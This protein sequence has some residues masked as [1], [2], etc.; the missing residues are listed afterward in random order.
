M[1][2]KGKGG[3]EGLFLEWMGNKTTKGMRLGEAASL[4][5]GKPSLC[6]KLGWKEAG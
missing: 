1:E 2:G 5:R 6:P 4:P 3:R